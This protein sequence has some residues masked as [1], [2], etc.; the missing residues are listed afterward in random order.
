MLRMVPLSQMGEDAAHIPPIPT[1]NPLKSLTSRPRHATAPNNL[2]IA[3][4]PAPILTSSRCRGGRLGQAIRCGGGVEFEREASTAPV[5]QV[6]PSP[7]RGQAG[8]QT[9]TASG[10]RSD[11]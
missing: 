4:D 6:P 11:R 1:P 10:Q 9:G 3:L 8:D 2:P 7:A 5:V